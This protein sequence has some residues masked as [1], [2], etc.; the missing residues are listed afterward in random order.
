VKD[1]VPKLLVVSSLDGW[2][3]QWDRLVDLSPLP[4]PFLRSWWLTGTGG[5]HRCFL[6]AV[7]RDQLLGG[8]ALEEE[9][10]LGL[11]LL[12]MMSS[13]H[14]CPDHVDL[15]AAPGEEDATIRALRAWFR[16]PGARLLDL[17]GVPADSRL[18]EALP[19]PA[20]R[21]PFAVAP[22]TPLPDDSKAYLAA[23]SSQARR[24]VRRASTRLEAEGVIHR[25]NRGSSA[26]RSLETLRQLHQAQWGDRS[27]FLSH[28]DRFAAGCRLGA[29]FDEVV[30]HELAKGETVICTVVSFEVAGRVSLYQSARI[31][32]SPS[33]DAMSVLLTA[34]ITDACDRGFTEVDF[35]RGEEPYKGKFAPKRREMFRLLAARGAVS[36][37][38]RVAKTTAF[39]TR[40][41][42][43][44]SVH[45]G[46]DAF[47]RVKP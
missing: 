24:L 25:T 12:R 19:S 4:S 23:L 22:W 3:T 27:R 37:T 15:L 10:R 16:R 42:A 14:L 20:R 17:E 5:P 47:S 30:V 2:K 43:E 13:G 6:L 41:I 31:T 33:R 40:R 11:Q 35:L 1:S 7:D 45:V 29:E 38:A 9:R 39:T 21:I 34:I 26:V 46:R 32:D 36:R 28:F 8:L 18:I 44:R